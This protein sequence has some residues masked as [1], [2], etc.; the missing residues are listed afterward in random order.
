MKHFRRISGIVLILIVVMMS[1]GCQRNYDASGYTNAILDLQFQGDTKA[2]ITFVEG[3]TQSS[4]MEMYRE[5]VDDFLTGYI[6]DGME[7]TDEQEKEFS[8]LL[9]RIFASMRYEVGEAEKTGEK[10]YEVP[11]VIRPID[12]FIRYRQL[13]TEDSIKISGKVQSGEYKGS[14][15]EIQ[16][17]IME[18]ITVNAYQLLEK[19]YESCEYD[20][21][22]TV[23][24]RVKADKND[25]YFIDEDDMNNLIKKILR[26]DEIGG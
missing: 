6:T 11:V 3:T 10:E 19:A 13:L 25:V 15:E 12:V 23:I 26:L 8:N 4:L 18:E 17:Q 7:L 9:S 16:S 1:V 24:L 5:F 14:E 2:A 22:Q 21:K 20:G